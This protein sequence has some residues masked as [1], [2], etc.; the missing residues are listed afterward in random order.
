MS[1]AIQVAFDPRLVATAPAFCDTLLTNVYASPPRFSLAVSHAPTSPGAISILVQAPV[2]P[3]CVDVDSTL[4]GPLWIPGT[5]SVC[6]TCLDHWVTA[7]FFDRPSAASAPSDDIA[8]FVARAVKAISDGSIHLRAD[9]M[10]STALSCSHSG[11]R[12]GRHPVYPLRKCL[13]CGDANHDVTNG[14]LVHCSPWTGIV[15]HLDLTRAPSA[16]AYR[17][18]AIWTP[19]LPVEG[20]RHL[21]SRQESYGRGLTQADAEAGCIAESLERYSLIYRGDE[22]VIRADYASV[23]AIHPD[24][25]QLFSPTQYQTREE[26]N[27]TAEDVL[28]VPEPFHIDVKVDWL[29]ARNL[30]NDCTKFVAAACCLMWYEF[31]DGEPEFARADTIGCASGTT[32]DDALTNALLELVERDAMAIWWENRLARP[33]L[34][35]ESFGSQALDGVANGLRSIGRN[36]FLLDCTTDIGIPAY[37]AVA[38]RFDGTEPLVAGAAHL[39]PS[40][41]AY[42]AA[43]EVGQVWYEARRSGEMSKL[44]QYW[45][46]R[47][48]T[49]TQ[50]YLMPAD[51]RDAPQD[52]Q[53]RTRPAAWRH[54]IERLNAVG[55]SAYAVDHSRRDVAPHTARAIVPGLRHVWNRRAPGRLYDV[56]VKMHWTEEPTLE[57]D[58]N[59]I[60]CMI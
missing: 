36:L 50:P 45:L 15:R 39:S 2:M 48:S 42:K 40:I 18:T 3:I 13:L 16:G 32:Y 21:L 9:E 6:P 8:C 59:P 52:E 54:I 19:P 25:V 5:A 28:W 58:L 53:S 37:V 56:P 49:R 57:S 4:I 35:L 47:E 34:R 43:S 12:W 44:L 27:R 31:A 46:R 14:L 29:E 11:G 7:N 51:M 17:A 24:G 33:G 10:L 55:L 20:A 60:R 30:S 38:P 26:W 1:A 23:D 22:A 41:A